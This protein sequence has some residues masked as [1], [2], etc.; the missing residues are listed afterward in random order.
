MTKE[1]VQA[2]ME[3][4]KLVAE[5]ERKELAAMTPDEK[6]QQLNV[7]LTAARSFGWEQQLADEADPVREKWI[8]LRKAAGV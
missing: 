5:Q 1:E 7:L 3:R 4:W 2:W 8:R 6:I